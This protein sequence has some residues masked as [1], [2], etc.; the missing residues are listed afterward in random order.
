[1]S[2]HENSEKL[3]ALHISFKLLPSEYQQVLFQPQQLEVNI[4]PTNQ[5]SKAQ[6]QLPFPYY[7]D[8][9]VGLAANKVVGLGNDTS[10]QSANNALCALLWEKLEP[11]HSVYQRSYERLKPL[12]ET[13]YSPL[14]KSFESDIKD[15]LK[16]SCEDGKIDFQSLTEL[17]N[18]ISFLE[19]KIDVPLMFNRSLA[20]PHGILDILHTLYSLLYNMRA[21]IAMEYN[22]HIEEMCYD[23]L[24][25][26]PISDYISSIENNVNESLLYYH[27]N[28]L[29]QHQP[30]SST[31]FIDSM[32][33]AFRN[34]TY[35][36]HQLTKAL[37]KEF[38]K[39]KQIDVIEQGLFMFQVDWLL[40]SPS[41]LLFRLKEELYGLKE[42][43]EKIFWT[44]L[45][46]KSK[47]QVH[48][49]LAAECMIGP[50]QLKKLSEAA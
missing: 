43:Y 50:D 6:L 7:T 10:F 40:G 25:L 48:T 36:G 35:H 22:A 24:K 1:M 20:L 28:A 39:Q 49:T 13:K 4:S 11:M 41:G 30:H 26:D 21:L 9:L 2:W 34:F 31:H 42:T 23:G 16:D 29:N 38:F 15:I 5:N 8:A 27:W 47:E 17:V 37:P 14:S 32:E 18:A 12:L 19:K 45:L 46:K 33:Q 44:D 3:N